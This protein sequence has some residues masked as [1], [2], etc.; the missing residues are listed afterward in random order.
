MRIQF[1]AQELFFENDGDVAYANLMGG[2]GGEPE[3][4]LIFQRGLMDDDQA[5]HLEY[6]DQSNGAYDAIASCHLEREQLTVDL[7]RPLGSLTDVT[8]FDVTL[9]LDDDS[10]EQLTTAFG[11]FFQG[12]DL[13]K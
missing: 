6:N 7:A 5:I 9:A 4:F 10:Y 2:E 1:T 13:L 12:T 11:L 3:H 8:G